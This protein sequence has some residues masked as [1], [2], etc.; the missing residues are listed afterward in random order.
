[1]MKNRSCVS[2]STNRGTAHLGMH[3]SLNTDVLTALSWGM[4]CTTVGSLGWIRMTEMGI[5]T[6]MVKGA[7]AGITK[8]EGGRDQG[9]RGVNTTDVTVPHTKVLVTAT[10]ITIIMATN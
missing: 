10:T 9:H 8:I 4:V 5:I 7:G 3:A 6:D 1:M 2:S